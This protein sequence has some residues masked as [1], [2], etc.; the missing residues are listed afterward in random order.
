[1]AVAIVYFFGTATQWHKWGALVFLLIAISLAAVVAV[2]SPGGEARTTIEDGSYTVMGVVLQS[3]GPA[4][5]GPSGGDYNLLLVE[6]NG[7]TR[8]YRFSYHVVEVR[9]SAKQEVTVVSGQGLRKLTLFFPL[10]EI[11]G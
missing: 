7:D 4:E 1:M 2:A 11:G 9:D 10:E 6:K 8:L 3:E 5:L